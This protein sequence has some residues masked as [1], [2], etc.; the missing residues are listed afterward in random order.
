MYNE[1]RQDLDANARR[2]HSFDQNQCSGFSV[3]RMYETH[4]FRFQPV[5]PERR[6]K[7]GEPIGRK[8][9]EVSSFILEGLAS[10]AGCSGIA[11]EPRP[12]NKLKSTDERASVRKT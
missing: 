4:A 11:T 8:D 12:I 7:F 5:H 2:P 10:G 1:R 9:E 6:D 3:V